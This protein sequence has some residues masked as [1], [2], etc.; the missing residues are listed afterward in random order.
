MRINGIGTG[1]L[2]A[3]KVEPDGTYTA[4]KVFTFLY[5]PIIP[6]SK[7][8]AKRKLTKSNFF[9]LEWE[10]KGE[11]AL[12]SILWIYVKGWILYPILLFTPLVF[13]VIEVY[14]ALG[15]P[16]KLYNYFIGFALVYLIVVVWILSDKYDEQGL[17]KGYKKSLK[18]QKSIK[19]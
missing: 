19:Q 9:E 4:Y 18:T 3:S 11:M 12:K 10:E 7:I 15:L 17:P 5:A 2:N 16:E 13:V 1:F 14:T 8:R 6:L